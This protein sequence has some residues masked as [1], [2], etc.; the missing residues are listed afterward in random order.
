MWLVPDGSKILKIFDI[1]RIRQY[2]AIEPWERVGLTRIWANGDARPAR[3]AS[4]RSQARV[5]AS[6]R[7]HLRCRGMQ[8]P[9]LSLKS[10]I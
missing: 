1:W 10:L 8:S 2:I 3:I 9:N 4:A 6:F 7:H 5:R